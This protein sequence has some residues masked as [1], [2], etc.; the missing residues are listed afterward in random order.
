M[1]YMK[2]STQFV[3][4]SIRTSLKDNINCKLEVLSST[5]GC[6]CEDWLQQK[7]KGVIAGL[8]S[9]WVGPNILATSR[10]ADTT[11]KEQE[12]IVQ[13]SFLVWNFVIVVAIENN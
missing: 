10:P 3:N 8:H 5:N 7:N 12:V 4:K 1:L 11:I 9:N 2:D 13:V 6:R